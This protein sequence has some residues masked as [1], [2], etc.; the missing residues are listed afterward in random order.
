[1]YFRKH[2]FFVAGLILSFSHISC[3]REAYNVTV[4]GIILDDETD[5]PISNSKIVTKCTYQQNIDKSS[6]STATS[7]TDSLGVFQFQFNKGYKIGINI[8]ANGYVEKK[9]QYY[10]AKEQLPD[11]FYLKK[12]LQYE[13]LLLTPKIHISSE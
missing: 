4:K 7:S 8:Y 12:K 1:M 9:I 10:P 6:Y 3:M 5:L 11:T 2:I 13:S